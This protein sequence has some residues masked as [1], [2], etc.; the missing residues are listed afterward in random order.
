MKAP[1]AAAKI[2]ALL[3]ATAAA[4]LVDARLRAAGTSVWAA[5]PVVFATVRIFGGILR[6]VGDDPDRPF[7][8][9]DFARDLV[10]YV[11][12]GALTALAIKLAGSLIGGE[13]RPWLPA[14]GAYLLL[15]TRSRR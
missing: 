13:A 2:A 10:V 3:L 14:A 15:G 1:A 6:S 9:E 4:Y 12:L 11:M 8:F 5:G 7:F